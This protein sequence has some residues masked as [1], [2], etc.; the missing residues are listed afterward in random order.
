VESN[1][2]PHA[3]AALFPGKEPHHVLSRRLGGVCRRSGRFGDEKSL[4]R[5]PVFEPWPSQYSDCALSAS[6]AEVAV[7]WRFINKSQCVLPLAILGCLLL[8]GR[9]VSKKC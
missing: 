5:L 6:V 1:G 9:A 4:L 2:K 8:F 7:E 3:L